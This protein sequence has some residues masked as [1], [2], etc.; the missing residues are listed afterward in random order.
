MPMRPWFQAWWTSFRFRNIV[1]EMLIAVSLAFLIWLYTHS[2][3]Q[4]SVDHV[5]IPVQIQLAPSQR[6]Q[7]ILETPGPQKIDVSF[8]GPSMRVRELRRK[9]Q[10]GVVQASLTLTV[11]EERLNESTFSE[12]LRVEPDH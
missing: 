4:N 7:Y 12:I 9:I 8:S 1:L 10:R 3:S 6:D 2:R 11:P 5:Q